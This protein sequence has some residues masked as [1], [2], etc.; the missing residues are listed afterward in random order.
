[1][2]KENSWSEKIIVFVVFIV[3]GFLIVCTGEFNPFI[4]IE[5][6]TDSAVFQTV[7]MMMKR[8]GM[9]Y[10]DSFD[11]KG[12]L[13]YIIDY[14]G[15][16][17]NP[18]FGIGLIEVF[19]L[20]IS[21]FY[22]YKTV[23]VVYE[24]PSSISF[25]SVVLSSVFLLAYYKGGNYTEEFAMPC[26]AISLYIFLDYLKNGRVNRLKI[27][28]CG[29]GFSM[30]CFLRINMISVWVIFAIAVLVVCLLEREYSKLIDFSI[31]FV[32][33]I[34]FIAIPI[35]GWM[36]FK[37]IIKDC[38]NSYILFNTSYVS[39]YA[40]N[41]IFIARLLCLKKFGFT[42]PVVVSCIVLIWSAVKN[43]KYIYIV[44]LMALILSLLSVCMSGMPYDHYAM[45]LVPLFAV[46]FSIL[47]VELRSFGGRG[48]VLIF[49]ACIL[50]VSL[51]SL[52]S[53]V[54]LIMESVIK[55][56]E[57]RNVTGNI[58]EEVLISDFIKGNTLITDKIAVYGTWDVIYL[59][60]QR[61]HA[62]RYS[63]TVP[64]IGL[65]E[66]IREEYY[67]EIREERPK[68]VVV[69]AGVEAGDIEGILCEE[70]YCEID[71]IEGDNVPRIMMNAD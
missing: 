1:M 68:V 27:V 43:K 57:A 29:M 17:I 44:Y 5:C 38:Y 4:E 30:V 32:G 10:R 28:L 60:S 23:R 6:K 41:N 50:I 52:K 56:V 8:G 47:L 34:L 48:I 58:S 24:T 55:G 42:V 59:K 62:T 20:A 53:D 37:G 2:N 40:G 11:H 22:M 31:C 15:M 35:I 7:A 14:V 45:V 70:G 46:P 69:Q 12:P 64:I 51:F 33:G 9:P 54:R 26:I 61:M 13:M 36:Y 25:I 71:L 16:S 67:R 66:E 3:A 19:A 18:R 49:L 21:F 39:N 65:S 63:Y